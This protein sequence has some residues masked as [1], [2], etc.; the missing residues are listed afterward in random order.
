M[1]PHSFL[2]TTLFTLAASQQVAVPA[3]LAE[4]FSASGTQGLQ[5]SF[6][7]DAS[8]GITNGNT[9]GLEDVSSQPTFALGDSSGVNRAISYTILMLD[10][11][12]D[13]ARKVQFL[14]TGF[15]A[16]GDKT[17][18][19]A[20]GE[21]DVPYAPPSLDSGRRQFTFLLYQQRG[22]DLAQLSGVPR[23]RTGA[24]GPFDVKAFETANNLQPPRVGMAI[25]VDGNAG[26]PEQSP[27]PSESE[28]EFVPFA[29]QETSPFTSTPTFTSTSVST[30]SSIS[31]AGEVD[32]DVT[33]FPF[34]FA[35]TSIPAA[36]LSPSSPSPLLDA[37][38]SEEQS[39]T[40]PTALSA[41]PSTSS[42]PSPAARQTRTSIV[43]VMASPT[44]IPA[45][46]AGEP[47]GAARE[48]NT[49]DSAAAGLYGSAYSGMFV[50][51]ILLLAQVG[52]YTLGR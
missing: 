44:I 1:K 24:A 49:G 35:F 11:T 4:S 2:V 43:V 21:P 34:S 51:A 26:E 25:I 33:G 17:K 6:G 5:V 45:A 38:S 19:E 46:S 52:W 13:N 20:E 15:K 12:D 23:S 29:T 22:Q 36:A 10:T 27:P 3:D 18:L 7:G 39:L 42:S 9:V 40:E 28:L 30:I 8:D 41:S 47:V 37:P 32:D 48:V 31:T 14:Q 16:T 50:A